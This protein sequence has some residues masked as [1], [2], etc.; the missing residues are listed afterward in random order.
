MNSNIPH[1]APRALEDNASRNVLIKRRVRISQG[2]SAQ[3]K[4]LVW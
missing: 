4:D 3:P 2:V 1:E